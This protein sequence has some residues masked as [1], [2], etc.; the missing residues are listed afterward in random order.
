[1]KAKKKR[2][3]LE[4]ARAWWDRQTPAYQKSTT[5]PGSVKQR[6]IT[7]NPK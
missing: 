3:N 5:R 1:M 6:I 4:L 2:K 7:G